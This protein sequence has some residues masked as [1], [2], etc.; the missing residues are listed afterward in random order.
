[1]VAKPP[2]CGLFD[3][4]PPKSSTF[5]RYYERGVFPVAL[6]TSGGGLSGTEGQPQQ[7]QQRVAWKVG[8]DKL[9]YHFYLPLFFDGLT[10]ARPPYSFL[11]EQAIA[12]MLQ[13]GS[14]RVLPVL[15][16]LIKPIKSKFS[17]YIVRFFFYVL[18]NNVILRVYDID[19]YSD[20]QFV[21]ITQ[22]HIV[23]TLSRRI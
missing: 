16:Q 13:A 23:N 1:M 18:G 12:D 2:K 3:E 21:S 10:E 17:R 22:T 19:L 7:Q 14:I 11:V 20:N 15:P 6:E 5:R 8:L 4:R 9:D